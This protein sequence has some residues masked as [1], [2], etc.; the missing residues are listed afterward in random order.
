MLRED[1]ALAED[2]H[3]VSM[4]DHFDW[5]PAAARGQAASDGLRLLE[6]LASQPAAQVTLLLGNHDVARVIDLAPFDAHTFAEAQAEADQVYVDGRSDVTR[7][8]AFLARYDFLPSAEIVA[9]D[10]STFRVEQRTLVSELL[11]G[12]RFRLA[13]EHQGLLLTHAGVT[14]A[15]L[16]LLSDAISTA[17]DAARALN[18]FLD[19]RVS[20]WASGAL[21]LAPLHVPGSRARGE[22]GGV[23]YHRAADPKHGETRQFQARRR[24]DPRGLPTQFAQAIGHVRDPKCRAL[25]PDWCA[26]TATPEGRVRSL[27]L[28]T[29]GVRYASGCNDS[30][31]LFFLDGGMN[32]VDVARFELFDVGRRRP[33]T[34][35]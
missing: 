27:W 23:L 2:V 8:A 16:S 32:H 1:G 29:D 7:E 21:D 34:S 24:F 15:D 10:Y 3:L 26:D 6:W 20:S 22:G 12:G 28:R 9:R 35:P 5:G 13:L 30:A 33:L 18:A 31:Q 11:R 19:A 4:G 17:S 25:M 14:L